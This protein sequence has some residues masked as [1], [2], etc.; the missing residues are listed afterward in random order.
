VH[1]KS[2]TAKPES[3]PDFEVLEVESESSE[4]SE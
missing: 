4:V 3:K 1:Y 2:R